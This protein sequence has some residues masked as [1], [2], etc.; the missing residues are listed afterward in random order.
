[1]GG[2]IEPILTLGKIGLIGG[3]LS[4]FHFAKQELFLL[5]SAIQFYLKMKGSQS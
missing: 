2:I 5:C 1:M 4:S 3:F